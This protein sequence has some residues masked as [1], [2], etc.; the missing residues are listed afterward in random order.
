M[1]VQKTLFPE[2]VIELQKLDKK[3]SKLE[4]KVLSLSSEFKMLDH[5]VNMLRVVN[6]E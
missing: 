3:L 6:H 2:Y 5:E 4:R 1:V